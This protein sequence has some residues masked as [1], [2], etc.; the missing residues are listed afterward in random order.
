M[1]PCKRDW[2]KGKLQPQILPW[3]I[4]G[5]SSFSLQVWVRQTPAVHHCLPAWNGH[6]LLPCLD[7]AIRPR[8]PGRPLLLGV[9]HPRN[10]A[11]SLGPKLGP[12]WYNSDTCNLILAQDFSSPVF[13][14][15]ENLGEYGSSSWIMISPNCWLILGSITACC[16]GKKPAI[17]YQFY[18]HEF[19]LKIEFNPRSIPTRDVSWNWGT[20]KPFASPSKMTSNLHDSGVPPFEK[21]P[22]EQCSKQSAMSLYWLME[23]SMMA[24]DNGI[25][26]S[27]SVYNHQPT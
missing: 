16:L 18:P 3:N 20:P 2:L 7:E 26:G 5:S 19:C 17:I 6:K 23:I 27:I 24:Y 13:W 8:K 10:G 11:Q 22:V 14:G 25:S 9:P 4:Q 1:V 21:L 15:L 12:E